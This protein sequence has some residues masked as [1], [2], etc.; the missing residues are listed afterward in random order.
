MLHSKAY[1]CFQLTIV[2][3]TFLLPSIAT[4]AILITALAGCG[5]KGPL[6]LPKDPAKNPA[7]APAKT[8]SAT[9]GKD[10]TAQQT[11]TSPK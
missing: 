1:Q 2:K 3:P 7:T 9:D 11:S 4:C 5:Q 10:A 8:Q 6:Y